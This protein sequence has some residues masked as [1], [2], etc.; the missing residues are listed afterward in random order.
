MDVLSLFI[1][2][3]S[4]S[5]GCF[6]CGIYTVCKMP[7]ALPPYGKLQASSEKRMTGVGRGGS[8]AAND[9]YIIT[10]TAWCAKR[11]NGL[12]TVRLAVVLVVY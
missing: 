11:D 7:I 2:D 9:G 4:H 10:S 8:C 5:G 1:S 6:A 12:T 3:L